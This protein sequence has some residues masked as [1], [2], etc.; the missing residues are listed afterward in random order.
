M[1][2]KPLRRLSGTINITSSRFTQLGIAMMRTFRKK[3]EQVYISSYDWHIVSIWQ[4]DCRNTFNVPSCTSVFF[5]PKYQCSLNSWMALFITKS[6][7]FEHWTETVLP[8]SRI[9]YFICYIFIWDNIAVCMEMFLMLDTC[10][11]HRLLD[12]QC[13]LQKNIL[14]K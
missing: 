4:F 3:N 8:S 1:L 13:L 9:M 12:D 2:W 11:L 5:T 6:G 7:E 10:V 14:D